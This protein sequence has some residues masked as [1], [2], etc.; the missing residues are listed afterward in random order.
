MIKL[1]QVAAHLT[2]FPSRRRPS[3][4][5]PPAATSLPTTVSGR[6]CLPM[7]SPPSPLLLMP[8]ATSLPTTCLGRRCLPTTSPPQQTPSTRRSL[9]TSRWALNAPQW[10]TR[11]LLFACCWLPAAA[12]TDAAFCGLQSE[13]QHFA[14]HADLPLAPCSSPLAACLSGSCANLQLPTTPSLGTLPG[15]PP[16]APAGPARG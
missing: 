11:P 9:R 8:A 2:A 16:W 5:C 6:R 7:T 12:D 13:A 3:R 15:L 4:F 1:F 10:V 14:S